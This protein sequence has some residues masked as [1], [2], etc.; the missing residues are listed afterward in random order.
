MAARGRPA[1]VPGWRKLPGTAERFIDPSGREVSRRQFENARAQRAGWDSWSD[2]QRTR[3]SESFNRRVKQALDN[4]MPLS[5]KDI[6]V[7]GTFAQSY[8]DVRT[9]RRENDQRALRDPNGALADFLVYIGYR[10]AE[11]WWDVGD[12][13]GETN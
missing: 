12:T 3:K 5:K 13:P 10:D 7:E 6:G 1:S 2:Y 9:A 11:D 8:V 4:E